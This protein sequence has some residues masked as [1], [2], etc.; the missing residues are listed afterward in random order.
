MRSLTTNLLEEPGGKLS[1]VV[2]LIVLLIATIT[3]LQRR[4]IPNLLTFPAALLA[5]SI[6]AVCGG[7][8]GA[9][10]SLL[11]YLVWFL[12]GWSFYRFIGGVGA[13]DIKLLMASAAF[14]GML[15][16]LYIAF[17][18]F[19]LQ[20]LFLFMRW[21]QLGTAAAN[22]RLLGRWLLSLV[23]PGL[24][25][26]HFKPIGTPDRSPH[27]PFIFVSALGL[28]ALWWSGHVHF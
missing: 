23:V 6:H 25:V 28:L 8:G 27:G 18:S 5:L 13:G 10:S 21:F 16:A 7:L 19:L 15:P 9:A 24:P 1:L 17:V 4:R 20:S 11:S 12:G 26:T 14:V 2:L 22:F 3:D